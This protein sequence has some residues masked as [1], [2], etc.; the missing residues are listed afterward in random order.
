MTR[1]VSV[2][3]AGLLAVGIVTSVSGQSGT[4][5]RDR[6]PHALGFQGGEISGTGL[7]Y[8]RWRG[9]WG[10]QIAAGALYNAPSADAFLFDNVLDYSLGFQ[11]QRSVFAS[12]FNERVAGQ[13]YWTVGVNHSG[14]IP[15]EYDEDS[16]IHTT[17]DYIPVFGI[18]AGLGIE[19]VFYE[20][21]SIP[22][23]LLYGMFWRGVD[24]DLADQ[25]QVTL[26][27][28]IAFRYR[29]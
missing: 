21:I 8:Q 12:D 13:L 3:L 6:N 22:I 17:G 9:E 29:Y 4:L 7:S 16:G 10:Y 5:N 20:H 19:L 27:P 18:G 15:R 11:L 25:L 28:Q 23:E 14:S 26:V 2:F 24:G 1:R